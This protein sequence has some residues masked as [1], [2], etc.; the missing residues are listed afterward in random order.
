MLKKGHCFYM[1]L[2]PVIVQNLWHLKKSQR[3]ET[4][5]LPGQCFSISD[6]LIWSILEPIFPFEISILI[7]A[8]KKKCT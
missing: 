8:G 4:Q 2:Y 3:N 1:N 7:Q 6:V 5:K